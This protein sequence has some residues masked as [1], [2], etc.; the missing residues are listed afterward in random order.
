MD[1]PIFIQKK[2]KTKKFGFVNNASSGY[3][4]SSLFNFLPFWQPKPEK[5][6]GNKVRGLPAF[7]FPFLFGKE[8]RE[9][10]NFI[11]LIFN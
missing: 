11:A 3:E 10:F 5:N 8:S 1:S 4:S 9:E 6:A 2:K 7:G